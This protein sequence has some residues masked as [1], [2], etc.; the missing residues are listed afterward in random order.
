MV[1][2]PYLAF[3]LVN[4]DPTLPWPILLI[5]TLRFFL[6]KFFGELTRPL[7]LPWLYWSAGGLYWTV[8]VLS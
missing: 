6:Q 4:A 5:T 7:N 1:E 2:R 3:L 8:M